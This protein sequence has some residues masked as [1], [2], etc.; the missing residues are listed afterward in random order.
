MTHAKYSKGKGHGYYRN[1]VGLKKSY[2]YM[3]MV[4]Q[5]LFYPE[6]HEFMK[7]AEDIEQTCSYGV[8]HQLALLETLRLK[9]TILSHADLCVYSFPHVAHLTTGGGLGLTTGEGIGGVPVPV[10]VSFVLSCSE[11]EDFRSPIAPP[12]Q[13]IVT[14]IQ[15]SI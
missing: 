12:F 1:M 10:V 9:P 2:H 13:L 8:R 6:K 11:N 5:K 7:A 4:E 3:G 14:E 15:L